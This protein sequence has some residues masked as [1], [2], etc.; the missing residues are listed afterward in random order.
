MG[1]REDI[2]FWYLEQ[3]PHAPYPF[4]EEAV[5][6]W[7][8]SEQGVLV[9]APTGMGKTLIA[10]AGLY[11]ALKTG[12]RAYYTTPLIALTEQ[13]YAEIRA[14]AER[15]GFSK[16]DV[17]LITGNRKENEHAPILVVVA[18]ILFN[19]LLSHHDETRL[20]TVVMDEFHHFS[21][22]ERGIVWEFTLELLPERVRTLLVSATVG[23]AY[24]FVAWLR[25]KVRRRLVLVQS[26]E[27]KVP[28]TYQWVGDELLVELLENM[29]R[30]DLT[31][32]LV[33]CFDRNECWSVADQIRGRDM[34]RGEAQKEIAAQIGTFDWTEGAGPKL[35][36][37]L[38]R[39]IGIHHA[40][41][42]PKYRRVVESLFQQ[43]L[44]SYCVCT[45]TL[46]A[47]INLPARSI[48][49][50]T[51][52]KG[53]PGE[54][55]VLD[56]S[57]AH[58]IFGRAGRPQYDTQGYVFALAH[59]DDVKIARWRAKYDR[60]PEDTKDPQ[61]REMKK[62]MKKKMPTRR[63]TEQYW[64]EEQ[65]LKL[66]DAPAQNLGSR[67][68]I[69]WRFLGHVLLLNP[70]IAPLRALVGRRLMGQKRLSAAQKELDSMLL[71]LHRHGFVRL[72][73]EPVPVEREE[74]ATARTPVNIP[75]TDSTQ[76]SSPPTDAPLSVAHS[77][78]A[79]PLPRLDMLMRLRGINPLFGL[80]LVRQLDI[81]DM[82]ERVMALES[83]LELPGSIVAHVRIP[84]QRE[85]PPGPLQ[86]E[87]LDKELLA[88]GLASVEEL[89]EKTE[90]EREAE[91]EERRHFG[92]YAEERVFVL[93]LPEK[94]GRLFEHHYPGVFLKMT[95]VWAVGEVLFE[96]KGD[97]NKFVL[98]KSL[99]KQEGIVFRH[100]LRMIL[101]IEEFKELV[102]W[103]DELAS[104]GEML[105]AC[106]RKIDPTSTEETLEYAKHRAEEILR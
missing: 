21:D 56:S 39:G 70:E 59:E 19:R 40:G 92:G 45:E 41:I 81:A 106:C 18:E 95:P 36:Q 5:L 7:F 22:P 104:L 57:S 29:V 9:S 69:P 60:I 96:F 88:S 44:L 102:E 31:P 93:T 74:S 64:N 100:L 82:R 71:T 99:Q 28:L 83:L 55:K 1:N 3:L 54:K 14:A 10:E 15:W 105:I 91:R 47:G 84:R 49:L 62:K 12:Q 48:V 67:G 76:I 17:G 13:K 2:A 90:E 68:F 78:Y 77:L 61:L 4:Q 73:P 16:Q 86:T 23:N 27:R 30:R 6:A 42:L 72:E 51:I 87:R 33:F 24:E 98:A 38:L 80:F 26:N 75:P 97:F 34:L 43:K 52:L 37:L 58:Q 101:L 79:R 63:S 103:G 32:G 25:D 46:A 66:K 85:L 8:S 20:A 89:L 11:E 50:P 35:R 94:L 53:P 65:F